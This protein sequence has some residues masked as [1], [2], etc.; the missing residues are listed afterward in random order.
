[1]WSPSGY[2][3]PVET[4]AIVDLSSRIASARAAQPNDEEQALPY[5]QATAQ[6]R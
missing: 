4:E 1:V 2:A 3:A 6:R 5:R